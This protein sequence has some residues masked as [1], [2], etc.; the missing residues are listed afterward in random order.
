MPLIDGDTYG[1]LV[2]GGRRAS[3]RKARNRAGLVYYCGSATK[4]I[5]AGLPVGWLVAAEARREA[6]AFEQYAR[7][8]SVNTQA[9]LTLAR[10][11]ETAP[12]DR[13]MRSTARAYRLCVAELISQLERY[14][15]AGTRISAP[16]GGFLVW[17]EL[18]GAVDTASR[19]AE[20]LARGVSFAPGTLFAPGTGF[21]KG[22]GL[23]AAVA[24]DDRARA[25][26]QTLGSLMGA[27]AAASAG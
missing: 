3:P 14:F 23:N 11:L 5:S 9:Q 27:A 2:T 20:A 21:D 25:A 6:L 8:I 4:T 24:W 22:L 1:E 10:Y 17:A 18:P 16:Q 13:H 7:A 19:L 12:V 15:P 26:V